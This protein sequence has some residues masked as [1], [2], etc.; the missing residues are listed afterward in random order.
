MMKSNVFFI[1]FLCVLFAGCQKEE[2]LFETDPASKII[3]IDGHDFIIRGDIDGEKFVIN[4]VSNVELNTPVNDDMTS[5][6]RPFFGT[7]FRIEYPGQLPETEILFGITEN[8]DSKFE[9]VVQ[10][11]TYSWYGFNVPSQSVG[12]AFVNDI[13]FKEDRAMTSATVTANAPDN[14]FEITSITPLELDENL[15]EIYSGKLYKVEGRFGV[16]LEKW[17][18]SGEAPR[19]TVE[20]FSAIFYDN[21]L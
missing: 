16:D 10:V 9:D 21:S 3:D 12:E 6:G 18:N 5:S 17:D 4:H 1:A 7:W 2:P 15:D 8:G 20:Y 19:L 14:Y 11:R 13:T